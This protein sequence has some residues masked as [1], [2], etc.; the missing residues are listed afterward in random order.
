M[1]PIVG[2]GG[3]ASGWDA[4]EMLLVGAHAVQVGTA[5]FADPQA[6][7]RVLRELVRW[8]ADRGITGFDDLQALA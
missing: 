4:A 6:P 3:I 8:G 5:T 7:S 1:L 2:V